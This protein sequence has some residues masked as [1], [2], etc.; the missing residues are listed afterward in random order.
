MSI[1]ICVNNSKSTTIGFRKVCKSFVKIHAGL[2]TSLVEF[3]SKVRRRAIVVCNFV[4]LWPLCV[5]NSKRMLNLSMNTKYN[6]TNW[7]SPRGFN[8]KVCLL[9]NCYYYYYCLYSSRNICFKKVKCCFFL[10]KKIIIILKH[11]MCKVL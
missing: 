2:Q 5:D 3:T 10:L 4:A 7:H 6:I 8:S 9:L 11:P 1:T